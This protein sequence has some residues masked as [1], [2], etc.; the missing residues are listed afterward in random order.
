MNV[1]DSLAAAARLLMATTVAASE[2]RAGQPYVDILATMVDDVDVLFSEGREAAT[3]V[4]LRLVDLTVTRAAMVTG[5]DRVDIVRTICAAAV[6]LH[7]PRVEG[8]A[9]P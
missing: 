9:Q 2:K 3:M 8:P 7:G 4:L 6:E 1:A 5:Q